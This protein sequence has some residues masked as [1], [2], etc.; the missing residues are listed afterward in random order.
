MI[1]INDL[2]IKGY[3]FK[4]KVNVNDLPIDILITLHIEPETYQSDT[5][6]VEGEFTAYAEHDDYATID[7]VQFTL[8]GA[9]TGKHHRAIVGNVKKVGD[10]GITTIVPK[11]DLVPSVYEYDAS[12]DSRFD[13]DSLVDEIGSQIDAYE[14]YQ[15]RLQSQGEAMYDAWKEGE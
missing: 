2:K 11:W 9:L 15:D 7:D 6:E 12:N 3:T 1:K 13:I 10:N 4:G 14:V 8:Y 5:V